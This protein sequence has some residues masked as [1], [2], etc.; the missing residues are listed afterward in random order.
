[1]GGP[2]GISTAAIDDDAGHDLLRLM[3][4]ARHLSPEG[5]VAL[6]CALG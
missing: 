2:W 3:S 4:T 1:M 5:H 6:R